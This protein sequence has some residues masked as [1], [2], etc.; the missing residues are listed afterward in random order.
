MGYC[1]FDQI[2]F[3]EHTNVLSKILYCIVIPWKIL[4]LSQISAFIVHERKSFI[5][6][7][8]DMRVSK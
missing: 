8:N 5:L 3:V 4:C 7:W 1:I 2:A 6:V